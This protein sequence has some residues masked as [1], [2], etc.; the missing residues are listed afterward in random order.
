MIFLK[1]CHSPTQNPWTASHLMQSKL[2]VHHSLQSL[3]WPC[4]GIHLTTSLSL[5]PHCSH[6][7]LPAASSALVTLLPQGLCTCCSFCV[8]CPSPWE[9]STFLTLQASHKW[10]LLRKSFPDLCSLKFTSATLFPFPDLFSTSLSP[11]IYYT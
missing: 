1:F 2:Q 8:E 9:H 3:K 5:C 6:T 4:F 7:S 10:H 11:L